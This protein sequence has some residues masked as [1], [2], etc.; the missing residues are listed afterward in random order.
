MIALTSIT[1]T[2]SSDAAAGLSLPLRRAAAVSGFPH[3]GQK[4]R[5][6]AAPDSRAGG[7]CDAYASFP[8]QSTA[9]AT[10][11][12]VTLHRLGLL[13][14]PDSQVRKMAS[15]PGACMRLFSVE[16]P[17][18]A[19]VAGDGPSRRFVAADEDVWWQRY[20]ASAPVHRHSYELLREDTPVHLYFDIEIATAHQS[21]L[22]Q[23]ASA[24]ATATADPS[25]RDVDGA[26]SSNV[27]LASV[28]TRSNSG[29]HTATSE[30]DAARAT[31]PPVD[32]APPTAVDV[33]AAGT[34]T[35]PRMDAVRVP[36]DVRAAGTITAPRVDAV[37]VPEDVRAAGCD[38]VARLLHAVAAGMWQRWRIALRACDVV[39]LESTS[40]TK[41]SRHLIVRC[42]DGSLFRST[43]HAGAFVADILHA[44]R[45]GCDTATWN[46]T[47]AVDS[48]VYTRNRAMRMYLSTKL[49][50]ATP[51][52]PLAHWPC[53]PD[54][55]AAGA[56]GGGGVLSQSTSTYAA[57][58]TASL[59]RASPASQHAGASPYSSGEAVRIVPWRAEGEA[60]GNAACD[61]A[62]R[63]RRDGAT[64]LLF[65]PHRCCCVQSSHHHLQKLYQQATSVDVWLSATT[66]AWRCLR[67]PLLPERSQRR[68]L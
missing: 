40:P 34:I 33:R 24:G 35:A 49:G 55:E 68:L 8:R 61:S 18:P 11:D 12:M 47:R 26:D 23:H 65:D 21:P 3:V 67:R 64:P 30:M 14:D 50:K 60:V 54:E 29:D 10:A 56:E 53:A 45:A 42:P 6:A 52:M 16:V 2:G 57:D 36:E 58:A 63:C 1:D 17:R 19:D 31:S 59:H 41:F 32:A 39:H 51:L 28:D 44:A 62:A 25:Q 46:W 13:S 7:G 15:S 38:A 48:G 4:R 66:Q 43:A 20:A 9:A 37:R 22:V 5:E 27:A